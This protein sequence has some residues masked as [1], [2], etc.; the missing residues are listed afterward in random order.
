MISGRLSSENL[1][2]FEQVA[3]LFERARFDLLLAFSL[4]IY[5]SSETNVNRNKC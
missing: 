4:N 5:C 1:F 2:A 3:F